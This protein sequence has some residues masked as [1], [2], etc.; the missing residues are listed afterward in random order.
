MMGNKPIHERITE[1]VARDQ[2]HTLKEVCQTIGSKSHSYVKMT[3][4]A[5][6]N[7]QCRQVMS[8]SERDNPNNRFPD[9]KRWKWQFKVI[10]Q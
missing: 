6:P 7:V 3:M 2:W 10:E 8:I 9:E 1:M 5:M 4:F